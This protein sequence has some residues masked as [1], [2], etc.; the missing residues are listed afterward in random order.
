MLSSLNHLRLAGLAVEVGSEKRRLMDEIGLYGGDPAQV[1]RIARTVGLETRSV[2]APGITALD[3]CEK[4]AGR[5]LGTMDI[6][7]SSIDAVV[8]VTQTPDHSQPANANLLH[9][10]LGL[11]KSAVAFDLAQGCSGFVYGLH[12]AGMLCSHGAAR[13]LLCCGDTLSRLVNP[14]DRSVAP[15]FGDAGSAVLLE[16]TGKSAPWHFSL[17]SDGSGSAVIRVTAGGARQPIRPG[18]PL[19]ETADAE[20]NVRHP[21]NLVMNGAEVFN[22]SLREPPTAIAQ[23]MAAAGWDAA[24]VDSLVLHQANRFILQTLGKRLGFPPEKVPVASLARHGNLSAAS[25]PAA[26]AEELGPRLGSPMKL[27]LCGFGVGL[28]WGAVALETDSVVV[29]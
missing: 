20:G 6:D 7:P 8:F 19:P 16:R 5:L 2:A 27:V 28:S 17:G 10:R 13:V 24:K 4:A 21:G 18:E 11:A 15:L 14:R 1:E 25:I 3:L 12:Y 9:G 22:F 26:L 29:A 23:V